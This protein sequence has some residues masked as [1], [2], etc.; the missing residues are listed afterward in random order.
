MDR[1]SG[2]VCVV[3]PA[4]NEAPVISGVLQ[5]LRQALEKL[6]IP[7]EIIVVDD[8][9]LDGTAAVARDA[10]AR[11]LRH[12]LNTGAGGATATGLGYAQRM[13][14]TCAATI[15]ADGQHDPSELAAGLARIRQGDH[16]L[17]IGSR[18]LHGS[19]MSKAK[20]LGNQGLTLLTFLLF[21]VRVTDS[22]SG[23]RV[24]GPRALAELRWR[25]NGYEFCSEMLWRAKQARLRIGE[26]PISPIYT[27]YSR[28]KGQSNWNAYNIVRV[29][30]R[31]RVMELFNE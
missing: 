1:S 26:F 27:E 14:F 15:D 19:G 22:Q 24:F 18:M 4:Y 12:L 5:S 9:S 13:G 17:L 20:R 29:L 7:F 3:V 25:S 31:S 11:V 8:G 10:G 6:D 16:D 21:G 28:G 2:E 30:V 23:M